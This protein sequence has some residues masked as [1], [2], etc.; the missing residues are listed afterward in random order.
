MRTLA[1][2]PLKTAAYGSPTPRPVT[3]S[4]TIATGSA[5]ARAIAVSPMTARA[6]PARITRTGA[7]PRSRMAPPEVRP[8]MPVTSV[9]E[10]I[11]PAAAMGSPKA[12][13]R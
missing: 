4:P 5:G 7:I 3:T 8:A 2:A 11:N 13:T 6:S 9:S 12:S 10:P 1:A